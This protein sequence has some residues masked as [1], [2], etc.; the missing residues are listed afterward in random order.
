MIL[1]FIITAVPLT[2]LALYGLIKSSFVKPVYDLKSGPF[3]F[4]EILIPIKGIFPDQKT[5]LEGFLNQDYPDY[6]V[7]FLIEDDRDPAAGLLQELAMQYDNCTIVVSGIATDCAQKNFNLVAGLKQLQRKTEIVIFCD[8]TNEPDTN[9]LA[10]FTYHLRHGKAQA[11]TTF[12]QF[13]P[14]PETIGGVS[15][16]IYGSFVL[17]LVLLNPKPW[18]GGTAIRREILDRL[19]VA[20]V[21]SQTVVDDLVLGNLLERNKIGIYMDSASMLVSPLRNQTVGGFLAYL[22]RQILFPKFTNPGIWCATLLIHLNLT[23]AIVVSTAVLLLSF[24]GLCSFT[25]GLA[26]AIFMMGV[27][28]I[29]FLLWRFSSSSISLKAWMVAFLPCIF[30]SAGVFLRSIFRNYIDWHGRRY[31][32]GKGGR[33]L[34]ISVIDPS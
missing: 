27:S 20:E 17:T 3:P 9:W 18:G 4:V 16:A 22:D 19:N 11:V 13:R 12:R 33:V 5:V 29:G 26:S 25:S 15:Q 21:W 31:Y 34:R 32:P 14:N 1:W 7:A 23:V 6:R 24:A 28:L 30:L 2:F 10:R 8:S